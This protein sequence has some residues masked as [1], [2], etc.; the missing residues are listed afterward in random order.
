MQI[1]HPAKRLCI[2][3]TSGSLANCVSKCAMSESGQVK[4]HRP[5]TYGL[6]AGIAPFCRINV[7]PPHAPLTESLYASV[8]KPDH[9]RVSSRRVIV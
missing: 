3:P 4:T 6:K 2:W 8:Q 1:I 9:D 5:H 7:H